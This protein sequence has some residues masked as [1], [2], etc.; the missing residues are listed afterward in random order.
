LIGNNSHAPLAGIRVLD[1]ATEHAELT[2][3][4]L[5]D[6]GAQV[7]KAEPHG[8]A[9]SRRMPPFD[10]QQPS[11]SL[12]W[13]YVGAGKTSIVLDITSV[14][15]R[16]RF[17]ELVAG[18]DVLIES[19]RPGF[20]ESLKYDY[21]TLAENNARLIQLCVSP[22]GQHGPKSLWPATDL[23]IEAAGGRIALQGDSD[24]PPLPVGYPQAAFQAGAQGAADILIA[25]NERAISGCGQLLDLS[26]QEVM[27]WTLMGAQGAPVCVASDPPGSGDDRST[28]QSG[29]AGLVPGFLACADGI[30]AVG[31]AAISP[32]VKGML[33]LVIEEAAET[34]QLHSDLLAVDWDRWVELLKDGTISQ[35]LFLQ[36]L[37]LLQKFVK[38]RSKAD[39]TRWAQLKDVRLGPCFD[40]RDL[41]SDEHFA[42]REFFCEIDGLIQPG[43]WAQLS[44]TPL[45]LASSA[46][47][48]GAGPW[49]DWSQTT[50]YCAPKTP[51][52]QR[53]GH[54]FAGLKVADFSWVAA[55]P[56]ITKALADH[57]ATVVKIE[58]SKR[59]DLARTLP[60]F[61]PGEAGLERS[62]WMS[63][64]GTSK[65]SLA[66][67]LTSQAGR[68]LARS[69]VDW[70]DVVVE[71]FSPGT[72]KRFGLDYQ[73]LADSRP[74]LVMLSTSLLGQ[75]GPRAEFAGFGQQGAGFAGLHA[76]TG[77]PD[78]I[79]SGVYAPYT[80]VIA[81]K[82][83]ISALAAALLERRHSGRGQ[84][85]DLSQ[86]ESAVHFIAPVVL[87]Y[88]A[89]G[90]IAGPAG[91]DSLQACPHGIFPAAGK[92]RYVAIAI[93]TALQWRALCSLVSVGDLAQPAFDD[94]QARLRVAPEINAAIAAWTVLHDRYALVEQLI[95][96]GIPASVVLRPTEVYKDPQIEARGFKQVLEHSVLGPIEVWGFPTRFSA[97]DTM[98]LRP[99][100]C[101]GEHSRFVMRE[102]LGLSERDMQ[103]FVSAGA[104]GES[105][106]LFN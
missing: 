16:R 26:M 91:C 92:E 58:S 93:E 87:D 104:C 95:G 88:A 29:L 38:A 105:S 12:Y 15:G 78:R 63:L 59:P 68:Q 76:I 8:G 57:G 48:L 84:Y 52:P 41:L 83:G 102:L 25:L 18:A 11:K 60:P 71:S 24:R 14:E 100:P 4:L 31:L 65:Y 34:Q 30:V 77:W 23:T 47:E 6:L 35:S 98:V 19:F 53:Q 61:W 86:V 79:P 44:R 7:I 40:A 82:F 36:A 13:A 90:H 56:T 5:A 55:G 97:R 96:A 85:I 66:C 42:A 75:T 64:Y 99:P 94:L 81:P 80:D 27:F 45:S 54:A 73:S 21:A 32:G 22:Y 69:V 70:A 33:K 46:P 17:L 1:L 37:E 72:M 101:Y 103:N 49:P 51:I 106:S 3:R 62:Y 50:P 43:R 9:A 39:L 89:N 67:D 10:E 20:L 2:G 28:A 74:D